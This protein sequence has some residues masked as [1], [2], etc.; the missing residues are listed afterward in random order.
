MRLPYHNYKQILTYHTNV[1]NDQSLCKYC[2]NST[3]IITEHINYYKLQLMCNNNRSLK[4]L[5]MLYKYNLFECV[6]LS[7]RVCLCLSMSVH[8][9]VCVISV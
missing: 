6:C 8:V 5:V 7:M 4:F 2:R 1:M 3:M 9:C